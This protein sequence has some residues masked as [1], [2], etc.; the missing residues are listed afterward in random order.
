MKKIL[1]VLFI[2]VILFLTMM[3]S[4][5]ANNG[6]ISVYL[7]AAKIEFDVKPQIINGRTMVPIRAIF[8]KMGAVVEWDGNTGSA[9]CTK[10]DTVVKMTVNSMD[11]YINNQLTKM[12]ISPVVIDGRTLAPARYVA[13]AF[14]ADVQWSQKNNSVVICSKDV[15]AYADYPDIPD[16]G[17]CFNI[18]VVDEGESNGYKV[19]SYNFT[20]LENEE[21]YSYL[22]DNSALILGAYSEEI[23]KRNG[24]TYYFEYTKKGESESRYYV[25]TVHKEDG[26]MDFYVMIPSETVVESKVTLYALD[27]RTIEVLESEVGSYLN[28]GWYRTLAETQQTMYAPDGRTITIYKSE[29]SSY[30]NVGWYETQAQA[31]AANKITNNTSNSNNPSADGYYYRTPSGKKYHL[32]PNCGGKNSYKTTNISG[33]SPCSKCAK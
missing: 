9:V 29:V 15:Y 28:V 10:G 26:T 2:T 32:D 30:K 8:E 16:L 23:I 31:Q 27:G 6:E 20:D 1:S 7:D 33:L 24:D 14:G 25:V 4:V 21:Y 18:P 12:D 17:R 22:Y 3:F 5:S 19:I 13:E 11:M